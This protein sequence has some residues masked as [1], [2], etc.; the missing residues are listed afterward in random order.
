MDE[1]TKISR[2]KLIVNT[3]QGIGISFL[4]GS[5]W[6]G[7]VYEAKS[8]PLILRPPGALQEEDFI[9]KCIKC[10]LCVEGCPYDV[11]YLAK[12][13]DNKPLGTPY[14]IPRTNPCRMC[15][16]IPCVPPCPTGAL[17]IK[18]VSSIKNG[19]E[20]LDINK[21]RM[22]LAVVDHE[23]CIAFW[24]IQCDACYRACPL[25][26]K[27]IT[28]EYERNERTGRHAYLRP[29]VHA[30]F[31]TG[32]GLCEH[33]CVTEKAAIFVLPRNI[34]LGKAG[35]HYVKGWMEEDEK[36]LEGSKGIETQKT[37]RT[38]KKAEDYLN[39]GF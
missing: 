22:G 8:D 21:A 30:D 3:L 13:G 7:F 34:A 17:N 18:S 1:K 36:R 28:L 14:F 27:A 11:L 9:K 12:P 4:G 10:G 2:R 31:C 16:D 15:E 6:A 29:L 26:D 33:A 19:K 37:E 20:A 32:C 5:L 39:E 35:K 38:H 24:G 23:N 25:I